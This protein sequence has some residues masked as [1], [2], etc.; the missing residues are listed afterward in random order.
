MSTECEV[1]VAR[2]RVSLNV[3]GISPNI[4][5]SGNQLMRLPNVRKGKPAPLSLNIVRKRTPR[6]SCGAC[7]RSE[8]RGRGVEAHFCHGGPQSSGTRE[9]VAR[10]RSRSRTAQQVRWRSQRIVA[11][12]PT[13]K[14]IERPARTTATCG[15]PNC[16]RSVANLVCSPIGSCF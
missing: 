3:G 4:F 15:A 9:V 6:W 11:V 8:V 13:P 1:L 10:T 5:I 7:P 2:N 16:S 12:T 14:T